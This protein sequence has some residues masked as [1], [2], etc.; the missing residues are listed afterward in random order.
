MVEQTKT[1]YIHDRNKANEETKI[2]H[3]SIG[4][5]QEKQCIISEKKR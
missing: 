4:E 5:K 1:K 3:R 2:Y